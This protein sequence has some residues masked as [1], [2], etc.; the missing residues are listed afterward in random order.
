MGL[1]L[2][3]QLDLV[4]LVPKQTASRALSG[5]LLGANPRFAVSANRILGYRNQRQQ[6]YLSC[7][8]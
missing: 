5:S 1:L 7:L 4:L 2:D 3:W 6:R 8:K